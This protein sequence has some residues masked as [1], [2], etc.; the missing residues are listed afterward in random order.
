[1]QISLLKYDIDWPEA[2]EGK[3]KEDEAGAIQPNKDDEGEDEGEEE[4]VD[5]DQELVEEEE[6]EDN[7]FLSDDEDVEETYHIDKPVH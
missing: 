1:M 6:D 2:F 7:P 3:S 5:D 4:E